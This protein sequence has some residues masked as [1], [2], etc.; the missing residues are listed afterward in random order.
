MNSKQ[1]VKILKT[2]VASDTYKHLGEVQSR[3]PG[4]LLEQDLEVST[5]EQENFQILEG[6]NSKRQR[7]EEHRPQN[8]FMLKAIDRHNCV[9]DMLTLYKQPTIGNC[10]L[11]LTFNG[12][13]AV[14]HGVLSEVYSV[15]W[16]NFV[17]SYC[18]RSSHFTFS[19]SAAMSQDDFAAIG[20]ILTDQFIQTGTLPL[21]ISEAIIQQAVIGQVSEECLIQ[22][23]LMLLNEK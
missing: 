3:P 2:G 16:D 21:Q 20:R 18:E 1:K 22:S 11:Y 23:F 14:G 4:Q 8:V 12:E 10:K 9:N 5:R 19:I 15:F 7:M 13:T 6:L 17:S